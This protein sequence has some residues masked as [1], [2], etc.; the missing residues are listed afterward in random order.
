MKKI[1]RGSE[2]QKVSVPT[3]VHSR[4]P[5][6]SDK[7]TGVHSIRD[8]GTETLHQLGGVKGWDGVRS[9]VR[10]GELRLGE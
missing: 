7:S 3:Y 2:K 10:W 9:V 5:R 1:Y 4:F 8:V 6:I